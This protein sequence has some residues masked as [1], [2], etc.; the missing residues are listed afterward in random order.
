MPHVVNFPK[1]FTDKKFKK[2]FYI[3]TVKI[4]RL[5]NGLIWQASSDNESNDIKRVY[6][7]F[8]KNIKIAPDLIPLRLTTSINKL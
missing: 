8:A 1:G 7:E 4:L 5:Y 2:S 6:G 3:H